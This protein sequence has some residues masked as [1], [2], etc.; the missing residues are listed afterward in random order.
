MSRIKV[1]WTGEGTYPYTTGGV[2]TWADILMHEL[3][4][5]DF[6]LIPIQMHP[7]VKLK[8]DIPPNVTDIINVPLWGTE[9]PTEYIRE[10]EFS[11]IYESKIKTT[12]TNNI[13]K[14]KPIMILILDH[15]YRTKEDLKAVG[16]ALYEFYEYFHTY[17]YY[18]TFRSN[19]L[20]EVYKNYI[21][22]HYKETKMN[23]PSVFD[24]VEGLRYLYRFFI[25]LL[26]DLPKAHIYHS[27]AAAFC[28]LSCIIAKKKYGSKFLLTEHG[29]YIREQYL[30]ASRNQ[31][32]YR[33]KE[34]MMGLITL[35]SRLNFYYA[36]M[37]SPVCNYNIRWEKKWGVNENKINTIYNGID[38]NKFYRFEVEEKKDRPIVV[39][40]ARIDPLKDIETFIKTAQLVTKEI[41][42][43][44]F[45]L[46]G[47]IVDEKYFH[48]CEKLVDELYM[49]DNFIFA[50]STTNPAAA[51]NEGDVVMLTSISE[52]FPFVV[53]EAMACEKVV[54]S[55]D[56]G[57]TKEVLEG[58]GYVVKPKDYQE[59]ADKVIYVLSNPDIAKEMGV[60]ARESILNGFT[61][62]DMVD[63][64]SRVYKDLYTKYIE[65]QEKEWKQV[66]LATI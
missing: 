24:M 15:I 48:L 45:K 43:V 34:F 10:I 55:S 23:L 31:M 8:F 2:S 36:D 39:M 47:P 46:Y 18:E 38:A 16:D 54:I 52:A 13:E 51:Y 53:I 21:I 57:G 59:F 25:S 30:A 11:K 65:V 9:E 14:L 61:I 37:V 22:E 56:V 27:S 4:N 40:V 28:G 42:D 7:Y 63:N 12:T 32:P 64:Y 20:W 62:E 26:P 3:K 35:V 29:V 33:T 50:G 5:I 41:P 60:D 17:D 66:A 49:K 6:T 44:L 58:Y 1:V 19:E